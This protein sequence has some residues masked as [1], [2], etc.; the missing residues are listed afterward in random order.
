MNGSLTRQV[1]RLAPAI[2]VLL[3][4]CAQLFGQGGTEGAFFGTVTDA[5]GS[6][7]PAAEVVAT[8]LGTGFVKQAEAD[9]QGNFSLFALPIG[10]YSVSVKAKGFKTWKLTEAELTVG[11]RS[12]LAPVLEVGEVTESVS[13]VANAELLQTEKSSA[14]TVIQMQQIRELPLDT[15]NPLALVSLVPGMRWDGTQ[16]GGERATYVQGQGLRSTKT[17]FSLDGVSSNAPMD[18][19]GTGIPNVDAVAE[20]SVETL[21]FSAENGR[22][23]LQVKIATKSGSNEFHGALWEFNQND[24]YNARNTFA[25]STPR[26]RRN[27][28]GAAVG[29]PI[30]RNKT[31]F[32]GNFEGTVTRDAQ[33]WNTQAVTSA[34]KQGNFSAL[35]TTLVDPMTGG[36]FAGNIIPASRISGASAYFAPKLLEANSP[37]GMFKDNTGSSNDTWEGTGRIDHQI[38]DT[39]RIY[40]R[41]LTVRQPS[42]AFGYSPSTVTNDQV[43]Q[44]SLGLNYSWT[45]SPTTVLT[46]QG[47]F[48]RT[49]EEYTNADLGKVNDMVNAG[50]QGFPTAGRENWI[51]PPNIN[52]ASGY[53]G[54]Y[55]AGWG[56]P[57]ALYGGVYN[58][59]GDLR[60]TKGNHSLVAGFEYADV[61]TYGSHGSGNAR[62]TFGFWNLYSGDGFGDFLLGNASD[63]ARNAPL[64]AFGTERAPYTGYF[65]NDSWRIRPN[66]SID[67][68]LRYERWLA[69]HNAR[70][71]ASTWDPE[72]NKVVAA[73][74]SDGKI[75]SKAFLTTPNVAA[76]TAGLWTTAREA[77]YPDNLWEGNGNWAPRI[78]LVYRPFSQRQFVIRGAYGLFYNTMTGNRSASSAANLPFWGVESIGYGTNELH[79]WETIWSSDPNAFGMFGM[80]EA[81]DPRLKP[82]RTQEWNATIQTAL[83]FNSALTLTYAGTK[84]DREIGQIDYNTPAIGP[85]DSLQADRPHPLLSSIQRVENYGK[86]WYNALQAKVERRFAAGVSYTFSYSFSRSMQDGMNGTDE[87]A[88]VVP[89]SPSWYNRGRTGFDIR[90]IEFATVLWEIPVGHGRKFN[91]NA[92]RLLDAIVGG[93]NLAVTEQAQ[94]GSPLTVGGGYSNL[95]NGWGTRSD[96]VGDPSVSD[97]SPSRW[98][99]TAAFARP[100]LYTFGSTPIGIMEGPGYLGFNSG[101]SKQFRV[102]EGKNLQ[103][104]WEAFNLFNRVNYGNPSTNITSSNFGKITSAN[105]ARYMQFGLKF[106]F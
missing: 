64:Y 1:R 80:G 28:F 56:V 99:N 105:T 20:F 50:I 65:V 13:V 55:Y 89:Y 98:F 90:H 41:Y 75:N 38:N 53:Q 57:G 62:G 94:S 79:P 16:S 83:P 67:L 40:G 19:G 97:P 66:L 36:A 70:N 88:S 35:S 21:N 7:V 85:H 106:L 49:R 14:E 6:A 39:Q 93:W 58:F 102:T 11:D 82:A 17:A 45:M 23:P 22:D 59:K 27:Q 78:G 3:F 71:A 74:E 87:Y 8:H 101:L 60:R 48:L 77:G 103:F 37:D 73:N 5:S 30:V 47:G 12:R 51:G 25:K 44:H 42:M 24:A 76:A 34:M 72:L 4:A 100:A 31:F 10:K 86:N 26:V 95:G 9:G 33:V 43:T 2:V 96:L 32:F 81:Q 61:H 46:L 52:L 104:R 69:R 15:R 84:V 18:E 91:G 54:I 68:G 29:G 92:G 63:S